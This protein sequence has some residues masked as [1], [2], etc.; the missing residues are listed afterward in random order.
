[1]IQTEKKNTLQPWSL[2]IF[3]QKREKK[4]KKPEK[5][6]KQSNFERWLKKKSELLR[7]KQ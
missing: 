2:I 3:S 7:L 5:E 4:F 1:M 6:T